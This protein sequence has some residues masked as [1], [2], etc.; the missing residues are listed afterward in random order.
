M[1]RNR[2]T[3]F[4]KLK[5]E[6]KLD[7]LI[8]KIFGN[9]ADWRTLTCHHCDCEWHSKKS[10]QDMIKSSDGNEYALC[11]QCGTPNKYLNKK[12]FGKAKK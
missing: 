6:R 7:I 1:K 8:S 11:W 12:Y 10:Q 3:R 4:Y 9:I 5:L 2:I